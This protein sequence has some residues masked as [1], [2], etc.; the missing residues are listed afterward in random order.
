[1]LITNVFHFAHTIS[2]I[3]VVMNYLSLLPYCIMDLL[4]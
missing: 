4:K 2:V 3:V 1:M